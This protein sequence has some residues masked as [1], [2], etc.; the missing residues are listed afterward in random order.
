MNVR[1]IIIVGKEPFWSYIITF[2]RMYTTL[3][4]SWLWKEKW[5]KKRQKRPGI[6]QKF[7]IFFHKKKI[8]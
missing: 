1:E 3:N 7:F 6:F 2:L 8:I 5:K 4:V